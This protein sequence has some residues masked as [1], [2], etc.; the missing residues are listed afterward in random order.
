MDVESAGLSNHA[1]VPLSP[2]AG[3]VGGCGFRD[4]DAR[5]AAY[6]CESSPVHIWRSGPAERISV[7]VA[8]T[9]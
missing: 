9:W 1:V 3:R 4:G 7:S 2:R 6:I 8:E 5:T